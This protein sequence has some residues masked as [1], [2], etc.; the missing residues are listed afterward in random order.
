MQT[1]M[2]K[3]TEYIDNL[4]YLMP[5]TEAAA[6]MRQKLIESSEDKYEALLSWGRSE[7]E[8]LGIVV[9]EFGSMEEI[10]EELGVNPLGATNNLNAV[11]EMHLGFAQLGKRFAMGLSAG[12][13]LCILGLLGC[14]FFSEV[15]W[16]DMMAVTS[17]FL[18]GGAGAVVIVYSAL[19]YARNKK[20]LQMGIS[21][22]Q[23]KN[24]SGRHWTKKAEEVIC[25]LIMLGV[26]ALFFLAG[27]LGGAWHP[28]W[29]LFPLG[30]ILCGIISVILEAI[31]RSN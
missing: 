19:G 8:A 17:L 12:I 18:L 14:I 29:V 6:E 9:S 27:V 11:Q 5:R 3:V 24:T 31:G 1:N 22:F 2:S 13:M 20:L 4:F 16:S 10:C 25:S 26:T 23:M 28:A 30:G 15:F 7:D 21:P